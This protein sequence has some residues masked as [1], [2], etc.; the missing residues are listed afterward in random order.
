MIVTF[1]TVTP[2]RDRSHEEVEFNYTE[3]ETG[4]GLPLPAMPFH[5]A[6]ADIDSSLIF[7]N[8]VSL[9]EVHVESVH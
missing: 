8:D 6:S 2:R 3:I 5:S 1:Y 4:W 7:L 9:D